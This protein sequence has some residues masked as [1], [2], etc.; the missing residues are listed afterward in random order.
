MMH[1]IAAVVAAVRR[2]AASGGGGDWPVTCDGLLV[3]TGR[4]SVSNA[5]QAANLAAVLTPVEEADHPWPAEIAGEFG[6]NPLCL[7]HLA[8]V[9][10]VG[11]SADSARQGGRARHSLRLVKL[12]VDVPVSDVPHA[13]QRS[14]IGHVLER[15][16]V[17]ARADTTRC[18]GRPR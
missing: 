3:I 17:T 15:W 6:S 16:T 10:V 1:G 11:V 9:V 2:C 18:R 7:V 5:A 12:R 13:K 8:P 4:T 14:R